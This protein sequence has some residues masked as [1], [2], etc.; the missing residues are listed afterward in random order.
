M[1]A[2]TELEVEPEPEPPKL[3]P[4]MVMPVGAHAVGEGL[5]GGA[6]GS[7][8]EATLGSQAGAGLLCLLESRVVAEAGSR[9]PA[10]PR[11]NV[12]AGAPAPRGSGTAEATGRQLHP[13]LGQAIAVG[14][15]AGHAGRT[16]GG[17]AGAGRGGRG[18]RRHRRQPASRWPLRAEQPPPC[19]TTVAMVRTGTVDDIVGRG[20]GGERGPTGI[21]VLHLGA[22]FQLRRLRVGSFRGATRRRHIA[23]NRDPAATTITAP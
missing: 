17:R 6:A 20:G 22:S 12:P 4:R 15:E 21:W 3:R 1:V 5:E 2:G 10:A 19:P 23:Q 16:L 7:A 13:V 9:P 18:L 8:A 14:G 11:R